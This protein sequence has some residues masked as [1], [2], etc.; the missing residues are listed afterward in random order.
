VV[1]ESA[2]RRDREFERLNGKLDDMIKTDRRD[3]RA[4]AFR[5]LLSA[6]DRRL[7]HLKTERGD[8]LKPA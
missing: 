3:G 2:R 5:R 7:R 8:E 4:P 1:M 6:Q